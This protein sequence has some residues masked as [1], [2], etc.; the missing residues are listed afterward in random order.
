MKKTVE[1]LIADLEG[2]LALP[3][4]GRG[5]PVCGAGYPGPGLAR[6]DRATASVRRPA[7]SARSLSFARYS[8]AGIPPGRASG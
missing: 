3:C 8:V 6:T 5:A 1:V 4:V 2:V 7:V